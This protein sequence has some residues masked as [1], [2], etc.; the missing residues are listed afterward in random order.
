MTNK[1]NSPKVF[2]N[3]WAKGNNLRFKRLKIVTA[4][5]NVGEREL[6]RRVYSVNNHGMIRIE[7][8]ILKG[9]DY[10]TKYNYETDHRVYYDFGAIIRFTD[11]ILSILK[12]A[13][14]TVGMECDRGGAIEILAFD[15][16]TLRDIDFSLCSNDDTLVLEPCGDFIEWLENQEQLK[17]C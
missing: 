10:K 2:P 1:Y 4:S 6:F 16:F 13:T 14:E 15:G 11:R 17:Y 3:G 9:L 8:Y 12:T 7:S 5:F